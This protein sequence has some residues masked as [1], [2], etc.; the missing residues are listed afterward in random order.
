MYISVSYFAGILVGLVWSI[1]WWVCCYEHLY[2]H[3]RHL[4]FNRVASWAQGNYC[5]DVLIRYMK[6][7]RVLL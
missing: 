1:P 4:P 6:N 5:Q 7:Y 3:I 2:V